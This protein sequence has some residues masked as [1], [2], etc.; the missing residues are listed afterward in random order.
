MTENKKLAELLGIEPRYRYIRISRRTPCKENCEIYKHY[1]NSCCGCSMD[2]KGVSE[3]FIK[4]RYPDYEIREKEGLLSIDF[5]TPA[6]FVKLLEL[7][8]QNG[9]IID[10]FYD[11]NKFK[12]VQDCIIA[13]VINFISNENEH[14]LLKN[15]FKNQAQQTEWEWQ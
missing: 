15:G 14:E 7:T 5:E 8:R 9:F 6:N 10:G 13:Q 4:E 3:K 1:W 2:F 11:C 12:N